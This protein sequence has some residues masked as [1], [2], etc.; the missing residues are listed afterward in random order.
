MA[1]DITDLQI[2]RDQL[3]ETN[4]KLTDSIN[5]ASLIQ[6]T[7]LPGEGILKECFHDGCVLWEPKDVVGG[8]IWFCEKINNDEVM[9]FIIDC[10]GHGV[11]GA[12][13]TMLIKAIQRNIMAKI[14]DGKI[15]MKDPG[16]VLGYF[17]KTMKSILKQYDEKMPSN[18]GFDGAVLSINLAKKEILFAGANVPLYIVK[19]DNVTVVKSDRQS[20]GYGVTPYD[21]TFKTQYLTMDTMTT[22]I[23][24]TDGYIDQIGGTK[25]FSLGKKRFLE[26]IKRSSYLNGELF[27]DHLIQT[28]Y[29]WQNGYE[30]TDDVT[31][32]A[33]KAR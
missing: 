25:G 33:F 31:L 17:N 28:K 9:L 18:A 11:P 2:L 27:K 16:V 21:Y 13:V 7:I 29:E 26:I 14:E 12:F 32:L 30:N 15:Y 10:T 19:E 4:Q 1:L 22:Y 8:D 20:V 23:L 3:A 6:S 24:S 5:Y